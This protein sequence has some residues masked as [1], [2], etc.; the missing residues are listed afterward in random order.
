MPHGKANPESL[1]GSRE[2]FLEDA[3]FEDMDCLPMQCRR[4][5]VTAIK[6]ALQTVRAFA[7]RFQ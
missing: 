3:G 4:S 5:L 6:P 2:G 7:R 1:F